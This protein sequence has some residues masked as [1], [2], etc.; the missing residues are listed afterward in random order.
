MSR[1]KLLK[2]NVGCGYKIVDGWV[3]VDIKR[4]IKARRDPD[5]FADVRAIPLPNECASELMAIHVFEHFYL[6]EAPDLLK[7]W[8]RLL[9]PSGLLILE[10]P[11]V[12]KSAK[13]LIE[14]SDEQF[15]MWGLY[16]DPRPKDP[17]MC[18]KWGWTFKTLSPLLLANGFRSPME[19]ETLW[20]NSGKTIR[21]FRVEATRI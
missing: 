20:H 11:D 8:H 19:K 3:N 6:W 7:E 10:M 14:S 1:S 4:D 2:L 17:Y 12:V 5:I 15:S 21:D 13:N 18:H 9:I 16:G